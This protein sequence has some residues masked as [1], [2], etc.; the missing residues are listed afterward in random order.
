[1]PVTV[2]RLLEEALCLSGESRLVL[3]ERLIESVPP[4]AGIFREQLA[5]ASSR[6]AELASGT[7]RGI[8]GSEALKQVRD[9]VSRRAGA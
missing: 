7:V 5:E 1:M 4:D 9:A 8:E 3:A 6:A 2:D